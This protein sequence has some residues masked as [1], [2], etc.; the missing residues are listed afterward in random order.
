MVVDGIRASMLPLR[1]RHF[2]DKCTDPQLKGTRSYLK[3]MLAPPERD[4]ANAH[5]VDLINKAFASWE[6]AASDTRLDPLPL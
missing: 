3:E 2:S 1:R 5:N 4:D 6:N